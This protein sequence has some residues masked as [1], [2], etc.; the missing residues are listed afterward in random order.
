MILTRNEEFKVENEEV[1][2]CSSLGQAV[3]QL[4]DKTDVVWIIGGASVYAEAL[5]FA[6]AVYL[7][8]IR[9]DFPCDVYFPATLSQLLQ[10]PNKYLLVSRKNL[11]HP[12][13]LKNLKEFVPKINFTEIPL[14][15][16]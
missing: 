3:T 13:F 9:Q 7:T 2:V 15:T 8:H 14:C 1:V 11:K 10:V 6:D 12:S 16:P 4:Q 5:A